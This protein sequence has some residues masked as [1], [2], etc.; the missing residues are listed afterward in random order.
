MTP[1]SSTNKSS[2][3]LPQSANLL[4]TA[5]AE[6]V[7]VLLTQADYKPAIQQ[8]LAII[9]RAADVDRVYIFETHP[10]PAGGGTLVSQRYEW[11]RPGISA[12]IDNPAMLNLDL[13]RSS[14]E[15]Y[16]HLSA[17]KI[18][19]GLVRE[20]T[21]SERKFLEDQDI[22]SII[23]VPIKIEEKFWGFIGFDYCRG[24]RCWTDFES[25]TLTTISANIA[26][27]IVHKQNEQSLKLFQAAIESASDSIGLTDMQGRHFYQNAAFSELF[28]YTLKELENDKALTLT[29]CNEGKK[30][31]VF[32][33]ILGGGAWQGEL[34][35]RNKSGR[36]IPIYLR[37]YPV[38][39]SAGRQFA[40]MGIHTDI[41][42]RKE[43]ER[44]LQE[45]ELRYRRLVENITDYIYTVKIEDGQAVSTVHAP[46]CVSVTGYTLE[47]FQ[48]DRDLWLKMV[49]AEDRERVIRHARDI[50][51]GKMIQPI[52][53]RIYHKN[54]SIRWV[55]NTP[56]PH[57]DAGGR[58]ISY[59]GLLHDVT[60]RKAAEAKI[61]EHADHLEILN[62]IIMAVNRSGNLNMLLEEALK[63]SMET[64][65]FDSGGI[66]LVD[67]RNATAEL[68][69]QSGLKDDYVRQ[70]GKVAVNAANNRLLYL[71][72][73]AVFTDTYSFGSSGHAAGWNVNSIAK[74]PLIAK[75]QVIGAIV[76]INSKGHAFNVQ[77]KELLISIGRQLGTAITKMRSE[78]ALRES[79]RKYRTI[80]EQSLVGIHIIKEGLMLFVNEGWT[81]ITGYHQDE[82]KT[83]GVEE[84]L[85]IIHPEDR[86][87]FLQQCR[88][89]QLGITDNVLS[90]YDC[91][92]LSRG[93][94]VKWVSIH[95]RPVEFADGRAV[96]G[97][98]VDI[99]DRKLASAALVDA[100][101]QLTSINA[102][103]SQREMELLQANRDKEVLL[104][105]IH[106]RVKNNLQIINSLINLQIHNIADET[107][108][109]L[110]K[111]CQ[112]R[113][114][115]IAMVHEKMYQIGD[116]AHVEIGSYLDSLVH[117]IGHV[118]LTNPK[119][120]A[121]DIDAGNIL[122]PLDQAIPC[123]LLVNELVSNS[124]KYAFP[125]NNQGKIALS[126]S[127]DGG[128]HYLLVV[129]DNGVGLPDDFDCHKTKTLGMQLVTTF[130][131]QLRGTVELVRKP[132]T[133]FKIRFASSEKT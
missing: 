14:P 76:L 28:G 63:A 96:V 25:A 48:A 58:M 54:G 125:G 17:G 38:R 123:A 3:Y 34:E 40:V 84:Y 130:V 65:L 124:M 110:L 44:K 72:G 20:F 11:A 52:E 77:E 75:D 81:K 7:N 129:S 5:A 86:S 94:D 111:E 67:A 74:I 122:L 10:A 21:E 53:H 107:A 91:R 32:A 62:R 2:D 95:S 109:G 31:E 133:T 35:M 69:C 15:M 50:L 112:N 82:V 18:Y 106:H 45:S 108:V 118:Y 85:K 116:L 19:A 46:N 55:R 23:L 121:F 132:G 104:K 97:M 8:A 29:F 26:M 56:V 115:T 102:H 61:K 37:A 9:G 24:D 80:T 12:Q 120:V 59:D 36:V 100:N 114:K 113:I 70:S 93:G 89:K 117:H 79:E 131:S 98:I 33:T 78:T 71:E 73:Q 30:Q 39:D 47:E 16:A 119:A 13:E 64:V 57:F 1:E 128:D 127:A 68:V 41:T 101:K 27:L 88:L 51:D 103:L 4:L 66:Y 126:M 83:W 87:L 49:Y 99:S 22:V 105:E 92:F 6:A 60:D 42:R 90:I 43:S